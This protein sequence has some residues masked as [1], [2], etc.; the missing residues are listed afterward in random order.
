MASAQRD[1]VLREAAYHILMEPA[2][3]IVEW[4]NARDTAQRHLEA[5]ESGRSK[6]RHNGVDVSAE[7]IK[8]LRSIVAH[9]TTLIEAW[10]RRDA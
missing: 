3:T 9:Y 4:R 5:F 6:L 7:Y 8:S 1:G 10:D 2:E